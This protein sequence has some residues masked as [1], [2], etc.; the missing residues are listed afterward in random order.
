MVITRK[1]IK[2]LI[3]SCF[4]KTGLDMSF[5]SDPFINRYREI[6]KEVHNAPKSRVEINEIIESVYTLFLHFFHREFNFIN[7]NWS[8]LIMML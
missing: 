3:M 6:D 4:D 2:E 7:M 8:T 5:I 1:K